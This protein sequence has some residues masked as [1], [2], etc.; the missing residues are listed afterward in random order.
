[1]T[2]YSMSLCEKTLRD[3]PEFIRTEH[4]IEKTSEKSRIL[5]SDISAGCQGY[6]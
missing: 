4:M 5:W 1:M 3:H 2:V 6:K